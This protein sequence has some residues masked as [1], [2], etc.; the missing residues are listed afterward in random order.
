MLIGKNTNSQNLL[1][2]GEDSAH[3][4]KFIYDMKMVLT[5]KSY[6]GVHN[7]ILGV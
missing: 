1:D 2:L 5:A 7:F 4:T 3:L 6:L